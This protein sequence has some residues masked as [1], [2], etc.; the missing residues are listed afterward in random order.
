MRDPDRLDSFY[1][2]LKEIHKNFFPDWR[3]SQFFMNFCSWYGDPF[4]LEEDRF[5]AKVKN[6]IKVMGYEQDDKNS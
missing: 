2:E 5:L 4:Y 1:D 6:Y 3:F